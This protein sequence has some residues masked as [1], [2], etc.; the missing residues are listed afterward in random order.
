MPSWWSLEIGLFQA[1]WFTNPFITFPNLLLSE[2]CKQTNELIRSSTSIARPMSNNM[3]DPPSSFPSAWASA[4]W[5]SCNYL[6]TNIGPPMCECKMPLAAL[7]CLLHSTNSSLSC[8]FQLK[9]DRC[10]SVTTDI[11]ALDSSQSRAFC[12]IAN[13]SSMGL[14]LIIASNPDWASILSRKVDF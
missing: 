12:L 10:A 8:C 14:F 13:S 9:H 7:K 2:F 5:I 1:F 4:G 3:S 11:H 6:G